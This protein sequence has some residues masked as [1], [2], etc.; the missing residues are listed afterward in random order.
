MKI[1]CRVC[2]ICGK[3]MY[4]GT[5]QYWLRK[6]IVMLGVPDIGMKRSD[7]CDSCFAKLEVYINHPELI[8]SEEADHD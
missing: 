2:D 8:N 6:P 3:E 4:G 7:V 5:F 1:R